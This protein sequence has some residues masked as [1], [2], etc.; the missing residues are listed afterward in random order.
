MLY[1]VSDP[2]HEEYGNHLTAQ[3]LADFMRHDGEQ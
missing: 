2:T 1:R 3:E